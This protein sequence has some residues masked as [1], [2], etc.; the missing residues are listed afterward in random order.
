MRFCHS[1]VNLPELSIIMLLDLLAYLATY[2][3]LSACFT[4]QL[5]PTATSHV[6]KDSSINL[7]KDDILVLFESVPKLDLYQLLNTPTLTKLEKKYQYYHYYLKCIF[8][9]NITYLIKLR[10]LPKC[11]LYIKLLPCLSYLLSKSK[12]KP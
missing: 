10:Q 4:T 12:C 2:S 7:S 5:N 9:G 3:T 8:K 11:L 1:G 6:P